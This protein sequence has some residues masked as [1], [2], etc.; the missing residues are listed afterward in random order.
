MEVQHE[1]YRKCFIYHRNTLL[2][3]ITK[4]RELLHCDLDDMKEL[5]PLC[6][7]ACAYELFYKEGK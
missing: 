2:K 6:I 7:E 3:R 4:I 1:R 5:L